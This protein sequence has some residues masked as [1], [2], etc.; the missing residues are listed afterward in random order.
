M[1]GILAKD[2]KA[3]IILTKLDPKYDIPLFELLCKELNSEIDRIIFMTRLSTYDLLNLNSIVRVSLESVPFGNLNTSLECFEVGL[4]VVCLVGTKINNR[5]TYGF[6]EKMGLQNEYCF[7][8]I[9]DYVNKAVEIGTEDIEAHKTRREEIET[10][11]QVLFNEE[12]S[13]NDWVQLLKSL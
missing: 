1:K 3:K 11:A 13:Y 2:P 4:P 7:Y 6:Y 10:R 8:N 9:K 5:F 12:E